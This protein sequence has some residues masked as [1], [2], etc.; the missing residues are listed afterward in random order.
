MDGSLA[1]LFLSLVGDS[2]RGCSIPVRKAQVASPLDWALVSS[3]VLQ[4]D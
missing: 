3:P 1:V 2:A 4:A